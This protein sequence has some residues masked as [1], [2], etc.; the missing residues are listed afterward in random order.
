MKTQATKYEKICGRSLNCQ[1]QKRYLDLRKSMSMLIWPSRISI[2]GSTKCTNLQFPKMSHDTS[3]SQGNVQYSFALL[4][5]AGN[6]L[7]TI[8]FIR[9]LFTIL[10]FRLT[11]SRRLTATVL[12][13][14]WNQSII[15]P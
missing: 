14:Q 4:I 11:A 6:R 2:H 3:T 5:S 13:S 1:S 7:T 12:G 10:H 15:C 8:Q 9:Q